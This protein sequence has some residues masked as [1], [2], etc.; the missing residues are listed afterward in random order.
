[1]GADCEVGQ[2]TT[3]LEAS[4]ATAELTIEHERL[5]AEL[6]ARLE[7]LRARRRAAA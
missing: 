1:M 5:W 6:C 3:Q 4:A 2:G 7:E